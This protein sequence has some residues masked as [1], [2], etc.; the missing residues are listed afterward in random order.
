MTTGLAHLARFVRRA[1]FAILFLWAVAGIVLIPQARHAAGRLEAAVRL[2]RS[3]ALSVDADLKSRFQSRFVHRVVL[4]VGG[5]PDPELPE[6]RAA[7]EEVVAAVSAV[8]GVQGTLSY[9]DSSDSIFRGRAGGG[10][11]VVGIDPGGRPPGSLVPPLREATAQLKAKMSQRYPSVELGGRQI[12]RTWTCA[13]PRRRTSGMP[14]AAPC[15]SRSCDRRLRL[16]VAALLP[17]AVGML[18]VVL[19]MGVAAFVAQAWHL[20]VSCRTSRR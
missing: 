13:R 15:Q 4:V 20:S 18:A 3:P 6:G 9:L 1:R 14:S 7:L 5:L 19:T 17:V 2:D 10:F 12:P 8:P 16:I 11:L